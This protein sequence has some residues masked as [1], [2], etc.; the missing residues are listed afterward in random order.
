[1][2][3]RLF[4]LLCL[5]ALTIGVS[6]AIFEYQQDPNTN[7][8]FIQRLLDQNVI[9][10]TILTPLAQKTIFAPT[11]LQQSTSQT[12]NNLSIT[13]ILNAT[14]QHRAKDKLKTLDS[15]TVLNQ[16]A[17]NKVDDMFAQ[18]YFEHVSPQNKGP[19]DIVEKVKYEYLS[20]GENLALGNYN[21][22]A[23]LVQAWMD[24][25]GHRANILNSKFTE[26]GISAK[27][28]MF[29]GKQTWLAVQT[30]ALPASACPTPSDSLRSTFNTQ[31]DI[32]EELEI[33]LNT[34]K[35]AFE[36]RPNELKDLVNEIKNLTKQGNAKIK[37]GNEEIKI[38]NELASSGSSEE[39]QTHWDNG[40]QLQKEGN[41]LIEQAQQKEANLKAQ[42]TTLQN[43]QD[44][45]N[46][47]VNQ[48]NELNSKQAETAKQLNQQ[49]KT[50]NDCLNT[51]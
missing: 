9:G 27:Q 29:E 23:D 17:T 14:N 8:T 37:Q 48:F 35:T 20:V 32:L 45:F 42:Q 47:I 3:F 10:T 11:P 44:L 43:S 21:S 22:D 1:M 15:N 5:L 19:A 13:G 51:P 7:T 46:I 25:P 30:F 50:Y 31:Q 39:A 16:A 4:F 40:E 18:Q 2:S 34:K 26:I 33:D 28:G 49:I 36:H 41:Q 38:G 24:S 12:G 6:T